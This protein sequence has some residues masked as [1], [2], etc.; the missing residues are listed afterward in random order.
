VIFILK[1][2]H[3]ITGDVMT[4]DVAVFVGLV[5]IGLNVLIIVL[6]LTRG[7]RRR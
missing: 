1:S 3:K 6:L 7:F 4:T 5:N 2:A